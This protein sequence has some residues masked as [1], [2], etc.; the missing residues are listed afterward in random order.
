MRKASDL[1]QASNA[2]RLSQMVGDANKVWSSASGP[3]SRWNSTKPGTLSRWLSR[4]VQT[5]SNAA[6][7]PLATRKRFMAINIKRLLFLADR[8]ALIESEPDVQKL[9]LMRRL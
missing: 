3:L 6:S 5:C 7:D 8:P 9:A 2:A 4:E 1:V